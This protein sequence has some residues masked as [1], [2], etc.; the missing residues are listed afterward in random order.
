MDTMTTETTQETL[1]PDIKEL[2]TLQEYH[3]MANIA[4]EDG[5]L[6]LK[7]LT[8]IGECVSAGINRDETDRADWLNRYDAAIKNAMQEKETKDYP[9]FNASNVKYP[10]IASASQQFHARAYGAIIKGKD[11]V[12]GKVLVEDPENR[13]QTAA[14]AVANHMSNQLLEEMPGWVEGLDKT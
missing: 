8:E 7:K 3:G 6:D 10:L 1:Q 12:K 14:N 13:L 11:V 2:S 5:P 9:F 4:I